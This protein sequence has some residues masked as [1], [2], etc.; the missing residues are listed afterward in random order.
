MILK[1]RRYIDMQQKDKYVLAIDPSGNWNEGKGVTGWCISNIVTR[2]P[3]ITGKIEA[4]ACPSI[5]SYWHEH[6]VL[7]EVL[8]TKYS[9]EAV[10][11]EDYLLYANK[12]ATQTN[13]RFETSQLIGTLRYWCYEHKIKYVLQPASMVKNRW[14][15][16]ILLHKGYIT[17][18]GKRYQVAGQPV[19]RHELDA[20]RH[21]THYITLK[22]GKA[23]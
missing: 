2:Q 17:N 3:V 21:A 9:I 22:R 5:E 10:I 14:S 15:N 11:I 23:Q 8:F 7:I 18:K 6:I 12:A 19:T 1:E 16:D 13:S 4:R 20:V